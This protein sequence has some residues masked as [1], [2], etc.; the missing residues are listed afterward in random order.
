MSKYLY[1]FL[2]KEFE[3]LTKI[4]KIE[5]EGINLKTDYLINI[6]HELIL[7]YYFTNENI[8]DLWSIILRKKYGVNY[9]HYIKYL[10]E[11]GFMFLVSN[12]YVN[13]KTKT[14]RINIDNLDVLRCKV[15]DA[16]LLKKHDKDYFY[17][18]FYKD[19]IKSPIDSEL[20]KK[21][22]EDLYHIQID[23][24]ESVN[25]LNTLKDSGKIDLNKYFKNLS[26]VDSIKGNYI[27]YKFDQFGRMHTNFTILKRYIRENFLTI[28]NQEVCEIDI[29]NSQPFFFAC[30]LKRE[31]SED[32]LN[33]EVKRYIECVKNGLLYDEFLENFSE[34]QCKE[35]A[36]ILVYK[37][38]F[39]NNN[40]NKNE[41]KLFKKLYPTVYN[42]IKEF[43]SIKDSY[44]ELSHELQLL[45]SNF[46][47]GN[48]ITEIKKRF[49]HIRLFTVHDSLMF[50]CKYKE[51]VILIFNQYLKKLI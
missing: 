36:K 32:M 17:K 18:N 51:E 49:P 40:D 26:S 28:D 12:Y 5:Y 34:I 44:K 8:F 31:I 16:V 30:F 4:K 9:H 48:V 37:V 25:H 39:G 13:K 20:R 22:I 46:I 21:L 43:K 41:N 50:P 3:Y 11:K 27:F 47:F 2:P 23:Y 38:L 35:E 15:T 1:Q 42:Y 45:E 24:K 6:I 14:Y 7:K 10:V 19:D 33:D 29:K